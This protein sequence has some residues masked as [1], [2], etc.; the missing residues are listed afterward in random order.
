MKFVIRWLVTVAALVAAVAIVPGI[1][2][3]RNAW[4]AFA[5][6]AL[7]LG[8]VNAVV[9]PVLQVLSCGLIILTLGLFLL[10]VNTLCLWLAGYVSDHWLH[11]GFHISGFWAAFWGSIVVSVVSFFLNLLVKDDDDRA[12]HPRQA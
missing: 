6:T 3:S 12:R 4:V 11:V 1:S 7:V 2:V 8:L 10:V 5:V 9:R